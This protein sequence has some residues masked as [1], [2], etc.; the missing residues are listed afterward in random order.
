MTHNITD[1]RINAA[2]D[3][4]L[5]SEKDLPN[6]LGKEG[7]LKDLSKRILER[8]GLTDSHELLPVE[9][10]IQYRKFASL[11]VCNA[12]C[13]NGKHNGTCECQ[14]GGKNHGLGKQA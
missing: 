12:K 1:K 8:V 10:A 11:H 6:I 7:L 5:E 9:R 2:V 14:C 4:L 13:V 3:I